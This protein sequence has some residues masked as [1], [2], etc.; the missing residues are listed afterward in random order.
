[1]ANPALARVHLISFLLFLCAPYYQGVSWVRPFPFLKKIRAEFESKKIAHVY[2]GMVFGS[3]R[4]ISPSI[5]ETFQ[6]FNLAHVFTPSGLHLSSFLG[7]FIFFKIK[8]GLVFLLFFLSF[9]LEGFYSLKRVLLFRIIRFAFPKI[10]LESNFYFTMIV[11]LCFGQ[12]SDSPYSVC[13]SFLFWGT[14]ITSRGGF[15]SHLISLSLA[16][17]NLSLC[18]GVPKSLLGTILSPILTIG[19]TLFFPLVL[20]ISL[21]GEIQFIEMTLETLISGLQELKKGLTP[22]DIKIQFNEFTF[23]FFLLIIYRKSSKKILIGSSSLFI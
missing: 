13:Y 6:Y 10:S 20:I 3:S 5:K 8:K 17:F 14:L 2:T 4:W 22:L 12:F 18:E 7:V 15:F 23:F 21:A 1:M 16:N 11:A 9:L 19:F